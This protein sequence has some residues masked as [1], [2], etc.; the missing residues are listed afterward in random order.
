VHLSETALSAQRIDA[1]VDVRDSTTGIWPLLTVISLGLL[2]FIDLNWG[3][4]TVIASSVSF[5][6]ILLQENYPL[7]HPTHFLRTPDEIEQ[8]ERSMTEK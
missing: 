1:I 5:S 6:I 7:P 8:A 3:L 2:Q 4:S